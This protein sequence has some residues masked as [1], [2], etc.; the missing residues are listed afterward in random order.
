MEGVYS[1]IS[2]KDALELMRRLFFKDQNVIPN[3]HLILELLELV[4]SCGIIKFQK[5]FFKQI[6][7]TVMGTNLAPIL[8]NIY[9]AILDPEE[10]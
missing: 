10:N 6:L 4:L 1:N 2:V 7:G 8:A 3:A 5:K 9:M